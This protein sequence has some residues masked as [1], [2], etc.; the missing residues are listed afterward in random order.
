[1]STLPPRGAYATKWSP[2]SESTPRRTSWIF[3]ELLGVGDQRRRQLDHRIAAVVGAA[4]Q[5]TLVELAGEEAAQQLLRLLVVEALL[6]VLVLDQLDRLKVAGAAHVTDDRQVAEALQHAAELAFLGPHVAAE[7]L[8]LVDVEVGHRDRRGHRVAGE[9]E[10]VGERGVAFAERLEDAVGGD[11]RAHRRVGRGQRLGGGDHV[12]LVA[13]LFAAE[14][15]AE[16]A[17]GAD[18]LVGDQQHVVL[19]ADL[20]DPLE[21][22]V[23]RDEAAARRSGP[24]RR[25][26]RRPSPAPSKTIR[27]S[28]A[29]AAQSGSRS[30]GQ[31]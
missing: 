17:P 29:S 21:V 13:E 5:A 31:R 8:V 20:P 16:P 12:R 27:S 25:S 7:V 10:A 28:I 1:M 30:S 9:G 18:H 4:D 11:H 22:A 15:V 6:G 2:A 14:V 19:V 23:G 24:A 3:L 26:P